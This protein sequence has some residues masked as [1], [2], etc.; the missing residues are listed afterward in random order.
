MPATTLNTIKTRIKTIL[1][2]LQRQ[3]ILNDVQVDDFKSGALSRNFSKFPV[4]VLTSPQIESAALTNSQNI[5]TYLFEILVV[6]KGE[7]VTDAA[8]VEDL[9]ENILNEFDNDPTLKAGENVGVADGAVEPSTSSPEAVV[10]GD[11]S[12]ISFFITLRV[13]A[14]RDLTFV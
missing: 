11:K 1:E 13:R 3:E 12:Y 5:R 6:M 7:E 8:Q 4:A 14:V 9:I 10:S 2:D